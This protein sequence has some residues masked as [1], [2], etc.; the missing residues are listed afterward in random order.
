LSATYRSEEKFDKALEIVADCDDS[1]KISSNSAFP[2]K[3]S[4]LAC[5]LELAHAKVGN[6]GAISPSP[7]LA[8]VASAGDRGGRAE[9][10]NVSCR[11]TAATGGQV[12]APAPSGSS[13]S[14]N[15]NSGKLRSNF[16]DVQGLAPALKMLDYAE[17]NTEG[18]SFA[19][20]QEGYDKALALFKYG[21]IG[22]DIGAS[23]N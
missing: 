2:F 15:Q 17:R 19:T 9:R 14:P 23:I 8:L 11:S 3:S 21:D 22:G 10:E 16:L 1:D 4:Y 6:C 18:V 5:F 13:A 7:A 20:P 12:Q